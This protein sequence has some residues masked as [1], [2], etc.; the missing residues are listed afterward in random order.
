LV[1]TVL[2]HIAN[3]VLTVTDPTVAWPLQ[4]RCLMS[5]DARARTQAVKAN[6]L[7]SHLTS[8]KRQVCA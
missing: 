2:S 5:S 4:A 8:E 3:R 7:F 6:F 1:V